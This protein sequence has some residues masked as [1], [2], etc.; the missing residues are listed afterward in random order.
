M[1]AIILTGCGRYYRDGVEFCSSSSALNQG[2]IG[3]E[4]LH[5]HHPQQQ[6]QHQQQQQQQQQ[7]HTEDNFANAFGLFAAAANQGNADAQ[8]RVGYMLLMGLGVKRCTRSRM[9][10][11]SRL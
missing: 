6:Q 4:Q 8:A 2:R 1:L 3:H 7:Q 11:V 5:S 10:F 9:L